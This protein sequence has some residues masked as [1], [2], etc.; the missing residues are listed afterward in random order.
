[1]TDITKIERNGSSP[2][3]IGDS[4][5]RNSIADEFSATTSYN[6]NDLILNNGELYK[7]TSDHEAGLWTNENATKTNIIDELNLLKTTDNITDKLIGW[8]Q[9]SINRHLLTTISNCNNFENSNFVT[10]TK[11]AANTPNAPTTG[12]GMLLDFRYTA[13]SEVQLALIAAKNNIYIRS[14][15]SGTWTDW[16]VL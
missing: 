2:R 10:L 13:N 1:M 14:K 5:V 7:F 8:N 3:Y 11:F 9:Q 15:S 16:R 12:A 4:K 6:T